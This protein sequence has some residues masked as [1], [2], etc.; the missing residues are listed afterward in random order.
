VFSMWRFNIRMAF[1]TLFG[2]KHHA[3]AYPSPKIFC[4]SRNMSAKRIAQRLFNALLKRMCVERKSDIRIQTLSLLAPSH[5][6]LHATNGQQGSCKYLQPCKECGDKR[7]PN[8]TLLCSQP[9]AIRRTCSQST[10]LW[11]GQLIAVF[12]EQKRTVEQIH[13]RALSAQSK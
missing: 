10:N 2:R 3:R 1:A 8:R 13:C 11:S 4:S 9:A 12:F 6:N 7:Q 5:R